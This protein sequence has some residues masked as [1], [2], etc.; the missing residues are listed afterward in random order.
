MAYNGVIGGMLILLT[1]IVHLLSSTI[2][3]GA[4][5]A[6]YSSACRLNWEVYPLM[7]LEIT[8]IVLFAPFFFYFLHGINDT[9][10]IQRE[11]MWLWV[12]WMIGLTAYIA[13]S[14]LLPNKGPFPPICYQL[15]V[16][17]VNNVFSVFLPIACILQEKYKQ[18]Q[19]RRNLRKETL[20]TQNH[21]SLA[22]CDTVNPQGISENTLSRA[23]FH[24][25][26]NDKLAFEQFKAFTVRD[27]SVENMLFYDACRKIREYAD[28]KPAMPSEHH[29][30]DD[31]NERLCMYLFWLRNTFLL[32]TSEHQVNL[33]DSQQRMLLEMINGDISD[34]DAKVLHAAQDEVE[35]LMFFDTYLRY[36]S[37]HPVINLSETMPPDY[38][39]RE[40]QSQ[41]TAVSF[42]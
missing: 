23:F 13:G 42:V 30:L 11:L 12:S 32:D 39:D 33:S 1:L 21:K 19:V 8:I 37:S 7:V 28:R 26:L 25:L 15:V 35:T 41:M 16:L 4:I 17:F 2:Q 34:F 5:P 36:L 40:L 38:H 20:S 31:Y 9:F 3:G 29:L 18:K 6:K 14:L 27:L 24:A 22:T 10:G